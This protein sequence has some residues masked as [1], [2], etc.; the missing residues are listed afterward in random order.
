MIMGKVGVKGGT[1]SQN[2]ESEMEGIFYHH[3]PLISRR[4]KYCSRRD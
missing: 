2:K 1:T 3:L 4:R